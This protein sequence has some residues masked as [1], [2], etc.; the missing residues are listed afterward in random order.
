MGLLDQE[1]HREVEQD[2]L[3]LV[4]YLVSVISAWLTTLRL[5][6]EIRGRLRI[7]RHTFKVYKVT[8]TL[9]YNMTNLN[10]KTFK[11]SNFLTL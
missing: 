9:L 10:H 2:L 1:V 4:R 6:S 8:V 11:V 3:E 7:G 5:S